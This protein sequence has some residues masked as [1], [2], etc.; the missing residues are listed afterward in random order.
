MMGISV[1][2]AATRNDELESLFTRL[3]TEGM[4]AQDISGDELAK[5]HI[6]YF[7]GGRSSAPDERLFMFNFPERP[8]ALYKFL[9]TLRP[10]QNISLFQYRNVGGDI[11][12]ILVG[13]QCP[14]SE[15]EDLNSFLKEIGYPHEECTNSA[16]YKTFLR[17]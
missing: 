4:V 2:S 8:G 5:T 16:V 14:D 12:K 6:R 1:A 11:G 15:R 10:G 3:A 13:I 7:M 9:Q 17:G